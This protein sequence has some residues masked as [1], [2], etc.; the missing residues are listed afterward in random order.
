MDI[1]GVI[2]TYVLSAGLFKIFYLIM[3]KAVSGDR[4]YA[5]KSVILQLSQMISIM[6]TRFGIY[7][8]DK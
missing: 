5:I 2:C 8:G 6:E 1:R 3:E 7:N 4:I